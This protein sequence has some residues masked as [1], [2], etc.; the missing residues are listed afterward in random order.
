MDALRAPPIVG[1]PCPTPTIENSPPSLA[2]LS[3]IGCKFPRLEISSVR[4][5]W[6]S[7]RIHAV[8]KVK[9][10]E[11]SILAADGLRFAVVAARFNDI[12]TK[13]LVAG[14]LE[15]FHRYSVK[16]EHIE[17]FWV[18]GSFE[19]PIVAQTLGKSG[20]FDAVVCIG[21][22]VRGATSHYDAVANSAASGVM[23]ASLNSGVPCV[24]GILT[25]DSM[26]QAF[27]RAGGKVGNKGGE[28]AIAA[29]EMASLLKHHVH[30][31][32]VRSA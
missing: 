11:G 10:I 15:A 25:C 18:P 8:A 28:A 19:V 16:E 17:V 4:S 3:R 22:I 26:D 32:L 27:D 30:K 5:R 9:E 2:S 24:F 7:A 29:I 6:S 14:A 23:S 21:A 13:P 20:K 12:I 31:K 1:C